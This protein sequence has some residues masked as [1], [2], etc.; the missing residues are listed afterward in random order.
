MIGNV[1]VVISKKPHFRYTSAKRGKVW[2]NGNARG[3]I[4]SSQRFAF[5]SWSRL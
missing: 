1:G 2:E 4:I 3:K 5:L